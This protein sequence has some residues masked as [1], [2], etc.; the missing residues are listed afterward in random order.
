MYDYKNSEMLYFLF[1]KYNKKSGAVEA[2][3]FGRTRGPDFPSGI[4]WQRR[5]KDAPPPP[6]A[7]SPAQRTSWSPPPPPHVGDSPEEILSRKYADRPPEN[8][9]K[10]RYECKTVADKCLIM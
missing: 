8:V 6:A 5:N 10:R 7:W 4:G 3:I 1:I 2:L 9:G